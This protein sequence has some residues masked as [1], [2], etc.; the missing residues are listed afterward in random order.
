MFKSNFLGTIIDYHIHYM[1][2]RDSLRDIL[3]IIVARITTGR[4][5]I[6][7]L[8]LWFFLSNKVW[9]DKGIGDDLKD[10]LVEFSH[11]YPF[12]FCEKLQGGLPWQV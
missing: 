4:N 9:V 3:Y 7:F 8:E 10:F 11:I 1:I 6:S 2:L 5:H 12:L